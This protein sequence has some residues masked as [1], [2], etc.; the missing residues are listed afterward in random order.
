MQ[1]AAQVTM[2]NSNWADN[3]QYCQFSQLLTPIGGAGRVFDLNGTYTILLANGPLGTNGNSTHTHTHKCTYA[4]IM[5]HTERFAAPMQLQLTS[6][7]YTNLNNVSDA[8]L[9]TTMKPNKGVMVG[10]VALMMVATVLGA[11]LM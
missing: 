5:Q 7:V 6:T 3:V 4:A 11:M 8:W 9:A 2:L 1:V 10:H